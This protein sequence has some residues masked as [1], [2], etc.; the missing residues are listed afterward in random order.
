MAYTKKVNNVTN[1][2]NVTDE[3]VKEDVKNERKF[4][5]DDSIP[6]RSM[7]S[8]GLYITG[9]RSKIPYTWADYG[10]VVDVEYRDL[11]Y[12]VRTNGNKSIYEPRIVIEDEDF[13]NQNPKLKD[14]YDSLYSNSDLYEILSLPESSMVET[15]KTLPNGCKTAL[16]GI[17]STMINDGR[18]DSVRKIKALDEVFG[19]NMLVT[20]IQ[21]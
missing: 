7:V 15:I 20:L 12:M 19:T 17:V 21:E 13:I 1:N 3:E 11:I 14:L 9:Y 10:D 6:C 16:K 2:T 5:Q 4:E 18:I 8:G